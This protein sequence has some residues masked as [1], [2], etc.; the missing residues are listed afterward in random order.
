VLVASVPPLG[1][2]HLFS[3]YTPE[4]IVDACIAHVEPESMRAAFIDQITRLPRPVS[5]TTPLLVLGGEDDGMVSNVEVR[6]TAQTYRTEA[7]LFPRMGHNMMV[8]P[9]WAR[10]AERIGGWLATQEL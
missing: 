8:E 5:I 9:D 10:V 4:S 6:A 3:P 1:R 7:E 2:E